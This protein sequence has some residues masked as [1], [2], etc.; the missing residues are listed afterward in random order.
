MFQVPDHIAG[1][2]I[3][4]TGDLRHRHRVVEQEVD[5]IFAEHVAGAA[6]GHLGLRTA[7]WGCARPPGAAQGPVVLRTSHPSPRSDWSAVRS[8]PLEPRPPCN[9]IDTVMALRKLRGSNL[10]LLTKEVV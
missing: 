4:E 9:C 6:H 3:H 10:S 1:G 8:G 2:S 7:T 5:Q